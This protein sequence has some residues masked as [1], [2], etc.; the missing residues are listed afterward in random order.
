M[1]RISLMF[2]K[3]S[4]AVERNVTSVV[5]LIHWASLI[6]GSNLL[7]KKAKVCTGRKWAGFSRSFSVGSRSTVRTSR[8]G[9]MVRV[10]PAA[11]LLNR[12]I[13][14]EHWQH[15]V[16]Y[17]KMTTLFSDKFNK[18]VLLVCVIFQH[19]TLHSEP[20]YRINCAVQSEFSFWSCLLQIWLIL[21][22]NQ[23]LKLQRRH[24]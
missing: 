2:V 13:T 4:D 19:T 5:G 16:N 24:E 10:S 11:V 23:V 18:H 21:L 12:T 9:W 1:N 7:L 17:W 20:A 3:R 8:A 14:S 22:V 15:F 6:W